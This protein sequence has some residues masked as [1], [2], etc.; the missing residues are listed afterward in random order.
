MDSKTKELD[1]LLEAAISFYATSRDTILKFAD[2][3]RNEGVK[4]LV[5]QGF[6]LRE[7]EKR[8]EEIRKDIKAVREIV[9]RNLCIKSTMALAEDPDLETIKTDLCYATPKTI[10]CC[11]VPSP[12]SPHYAQMMEFFGADPSATE[13]V[14][15]LS[16]SELEKYVTLA[17]E[18]GR[19]LPEFFPSLFN[20]YTVSYRKR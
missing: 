15:K 6:L 2:S 19:K 7:I 17:E 8:F 18:D 1:L 14:L 3:S 16:F 10:R 4:N 5:D 11:Q 9:D 13:G 20:K 12:K